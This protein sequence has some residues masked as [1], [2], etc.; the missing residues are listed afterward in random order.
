MAASS[1]GN[2]SLDFDAAIGKLVVAAKGIPI[3]IVYGIYVR[4]G[5]DEELAQQLLVQINQLRDMCADKFSYSDIAAAMVATSDSYEATL[6]MLLQQLP[7]EA[8]EASAAFQT[9]PG[10]AATAAYGSLVRSAVAVVARAAM[11]ELGLPHD[12]VNVNG[13]ACA[14]GHPI[15][16]SGARILVTLLA[17]L[18]RRGLVA[19]LVLGII[20]SGLV[21][22]L[23]LGLGDGGGR[24]QRQRRHGRRSGVARRQRRHRRL[25]LCHWHYG[26]ITRMPSTNRRC[27]SKHTRWS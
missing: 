16:A 12:K 26:S 18:R 19:R 7:E 1:G 22:W 11:R 8:P 3:D 4:K 10:V 25:L 13:G 6:E 27:H 5:H 17:A 14:L 21:K 23:S 9:N 24:R 2:A 20:K 15:G